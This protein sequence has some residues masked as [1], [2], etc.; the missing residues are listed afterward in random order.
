[1]SVSHHKQIR[2]LLR[3]HPDGLTALEILVRLN[4][5]RSDTVRGSLDSMPD[6]Y[7]DRWEILDA[8]RGQYSQVWCVVVPPEHCPKPDRP[9]RKTHETILL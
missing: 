9:P 4:F 3:N 2:E 1:M 8:S 7:V 6:V 5:K